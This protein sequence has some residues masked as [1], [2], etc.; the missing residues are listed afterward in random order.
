MDK[1]KK[2][3]R[4]LHFGVMCSGEELQAWQ[5]ECIRLLIADGHTCDL[6]IVDAN[7]VPKKTTPQKIGGYLSSTGLYHLY[8]RLFF[9]PKA[10][11]LES[12]NPILNL[13][14]KETPFPPPPAEAERMA[15][16]GRAGVGGVKKT[17][18]PLKGD[19]GVG[20][21][22]CLTT[23]K[24]Y[25]EYFSES[26][27]QTIKS[28]QLDF[29]LRFGFNIIRGEILHSAKNGVWSFHHDDEQKYRGGPP[30]FWEILKNDPVTGTILQ[31]LTDKLDGGIILKKG[32]FRT[33]DHSY[34]GQ[35][36]QLYFASAEWPLQVCRDIENNVAAYTEGAQSKTSAKVYK[37]PSN[38]AMFNFWFRILNNK[39][40]FHY[41]EL[42]RP[43]DWNVGIAKTGITSFA[44]NFDVNSL[45]WLPQPPKC[46][47]YADPFAFQVGEELHIVFEDYDYKSRLGKISQIVYSD[48]KFSEAT[49]VIE[50][51]FHLS[52]PYIFEINGEFYCIPESA[53]AK[54]VRLYKYDIALG[55]FHFDKLLL[56]NF[57]GVDPTVF[58]YDNKWWLFATDKKQS[59]ASLHIFYAD[60]FDGPYLPHGNNP[61]KTDIRTSRPAGT[62]FVRN[63]ELIRPAQDCSKT[64]G[65]RIALNRVVELTEKTFKEETLKY[66]GPIKNS[67]FNIGFHTISMVGD[68]TIFDGKRF[69]FNQWN[70][71]YKMKEKLKIG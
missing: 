44:E 15:G 55:V 68:Y 39:I 69:R 21:I 52:Y 37:A 25:S 3:I 40:R 34:A 26:D 32:F 42:F 4:K 22:H 11:N 8:Q 43:E 64:Y 38:L 28:H 20:S 31:R 45:T 49:I 53:N 18:L 46:K 66:I 71:I 17:L 5:V 67:K 60:K 27:I 33:I 14:S 59:N 56:D 58:K 23:K 70:F 63:D 10:K 1:Q 24:N 12:I 9:R 48:G 30:G 62:P 57:P 2:N 61:V 35:I 6:L 29:I 7:E 51:G 41:Q 16:R 54:Q 50:E 47:Y 19:D 13:I 36:D 65:G